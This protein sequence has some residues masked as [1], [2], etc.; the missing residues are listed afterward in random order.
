MCRLHTSASSGRAPVLASGPA[1]C[2]RSRLQGQL[3]YCIPQPALP[4]PGSSAGF[5]EPHLGSRGSSRCSSSRRGLGSLT[6]WPASQPLGSLRPGPIHCLPACLG[7]QL[8]AA[9]GQPAV[10]EHARA[11]WTPSTNS[12]AGLWHSLQPTLVPAQATQSKALCSGSSRR[13]RLTP[14]L[15]RPALQLDGAKVGS[16]SV[17]STHTGSQGLRALHTARSLMGKDSRAPAEA[18]DDNEEPLVL[19]GHFQYDRQTHDTAWTVAYVV[20]LALSVVG[21]VYGA[22]HR[23][24]RPL[25]TRYAQRGRGFPDAL[26]PAGITSLELSSPPA[27]CTTPP[28]VPWPAPG[29]ACWPSRTP[30]ASQSARPRC[31]AVHGLQAA[32]AECKPCAGSTA[33][34]PWR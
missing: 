11:L 21:G 17:S 31:Q 14:S 33:R 23:C 30:Q 24:S 34:L 2:P 1:V 13:L 18:P 3:D 19:A 29:A 6:R 16:S 12:A 4:A 27:R 22:S 15:L 28:P 8:H 26:R 10:Q 7:G 20:F 9:P 32:A 25:I 5:A